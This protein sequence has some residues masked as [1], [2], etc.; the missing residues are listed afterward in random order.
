M[1]V[2]ETPPPTPSA[3]GEAK[4]PKHH[5]RM[6]WLIGGVLVVLLVAG[7]VHY[8]NENHSEEAAKKAAQLTALFEAHGLAVPADQDT[9]I[10]VLGTDG[11]P[12]CANP[13]DALT[14]AMLTFNLANGAA[15]VGIR[16]IIVSRRVLEGEALILAVYCPDELAEYEDYLDDKDFDDVIKP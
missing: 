3:E 2:A 6:Y 14:Q 9:I 15:G 1:S 10:N 16:P 11:G 7:I 12:V 13:N 8:R 4:D 5:N